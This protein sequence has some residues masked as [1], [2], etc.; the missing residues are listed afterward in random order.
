MFNLVFPAVEKTKI[1][2]DYDEITAENE[3]KFMNS[4]EKRILDKRKY[5]SDKENISNW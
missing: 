3:T 5:W 2:A 1:Y 4:R